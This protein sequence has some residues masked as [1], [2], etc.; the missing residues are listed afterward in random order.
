MEVA[1]TNAM[2]IASR[3]E[4]ELDGKYEDLGL[5]ELDGNDKA[6]QKHRVLST[7]R[8]FKAMFYVGFFFFFFF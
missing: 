3:A 6:F 7:F 5:R 4:P 2:K 1:S 8:N